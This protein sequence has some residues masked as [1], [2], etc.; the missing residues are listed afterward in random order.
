MPQK[1]P[2]SFSAQFSTT[3]F[4]LLSSSGLCLPFFGYYLL[5]FSRQYAI[6]MSFRL[7]CTK[8]GIVFDTPLCIASMPCNDITSKCTSNV[9]IA[10]KERQKKKNERKERAAESC[11]RIHFALHLYEHLMY[12]THTRQQTHFDMAEIFFPLAHC[13]MFAITSFCLFY[14]SMIWQNVWIFQFRTE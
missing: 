3:F 14:H 5:S 7:K 4:A 2:L 10:L 12:A 13:V 11:F 6:H 1:L 8:S 9:A